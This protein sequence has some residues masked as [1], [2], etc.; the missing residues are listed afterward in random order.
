MKGLPDMMKDDIQRILLIVLAISF[1]LCPLC[2][3]AAFHKTKVAVLPIDIRLAGPFSYIGHA[4]EEV[5]STRLASDRISV[6]DPLEVRRLIEKGSISSLKAKDI[7]NRLG[8]DYIVKGKVIAKGKGIAIDL[9]LVDTGSKSPLFSLA[10]SSRSLDEVLPEVEGFAVQARGHILGSP[11]PVSAAVQA[12]ESEGAP[13]GVLQEETVPK[14]KGVMVSRMNPDLL[15]RSSLKIP[16]VT[17]QASIPLDRK[18]YAQALLIPP[19]KPL[20]THK[21]EF[22]KKSPVSGAQVMPAGSG[23]TRPARQARGGWFS[24][25]K[26]LWENREAFAQETPRSTLPYPPPEYD[27]AGKQKATPG[28]K[29]GGT[30]NEPIWQWY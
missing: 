18:I 12:P 27:F 3:W 5:L 7:A 30:T 6:V 4:T 2:A 11:K 22:A 28:T 10:F 1:V 21:V 16:G 29:Q 8:V 24:W 25:I 9:D 13:Q 14:N 17:G 23:M 15:I 26:G 20:E 19:P